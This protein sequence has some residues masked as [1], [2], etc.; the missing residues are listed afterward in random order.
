M[1]ESAVACSLGFDV[2]TLSVES[3]LDISCEVLVREVWRL[4]ARER[5]SDDLRFLV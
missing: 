1:L 3:R 4:P 5:R 2:S